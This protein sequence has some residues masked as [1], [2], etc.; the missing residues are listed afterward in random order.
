[1]FTNFVE[2]SLFIHKKGSSMKWFILTALFAFVS[3]SHNDAPKAPTTEA[4]AA[5]AATESE[6]KPVSPLTVQPCFCMKMYQ[7]VCAGGQNFGNSC[8]AECAGHTKWADGDCAS[9]VKTK[10]KSTPKKKN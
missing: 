2:N 8:E 5:S 3:C 10:T 4:T 6:A 1:M 7:P 9:A